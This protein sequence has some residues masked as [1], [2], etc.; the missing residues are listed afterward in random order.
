MQATGVVWQGGRGAG[1]GGRGGLRRRPMRKRAM[2]GPPP[3]LLLLS[4][5]STFPQLRKAATAAV[6]D[7]YRMFERFEVGLIFK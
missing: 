4:P 7:T 6:S 1:H 5:K 3:E 2:L